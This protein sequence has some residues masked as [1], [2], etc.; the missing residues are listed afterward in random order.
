MSII[1][2]GRKQRNE[3][4]DEV[5]KVFV[6]GIHVADYQSDKFNRESMILKVRFDLT[7]LGEDQR[8]RVANLTEARERIEHLGLTA[9]K[10]AVLK[11]GLGGYNV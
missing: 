2:F 4:G 6:R 11:H 5:R 10:D 3:W 8:T 9:L 7:P 1:K